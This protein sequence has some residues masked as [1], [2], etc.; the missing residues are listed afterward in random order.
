MKKLLLVALLLL[1]G[2]LAKQRYIEGTHLALGAYLPFEEGLY[3]VE[4]VQYVNGALFTA[5]TNTPCQLSRD[6]CSTNTYFWGMVETR[7]STHSTLKVER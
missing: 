2:C 5:N 3:G 4:L 7:E 1:C 6:Y